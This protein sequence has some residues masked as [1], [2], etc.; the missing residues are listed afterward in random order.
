M[1]IGGGL[2][3]GEGFAFHWELGVGSEKGGRCNEHQRIRG[4]ALDEGCVTGM[5]VRRS[6]QGRHAR[7][8]SVVDAG[9]SQWSMSG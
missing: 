6:S 7:P 3:D 5:V 9:M 4:W 2:F 1:K 8:D